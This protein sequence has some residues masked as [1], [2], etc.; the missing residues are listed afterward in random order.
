M[1]ILH[2]DFTKEFVIK[3][4]LYEQMPLLQGASSIAL[5]SLFWSNSGNLSALADFEKAS[6]DDQIGHF[7]L[8]LAF[9]RTYE[10]TSY[11][12][13]LESDL[14]KFVILR[15]LL[16]VV[17]TKCRAIFYY[18]TWSFL[19]YDRRLWPIFSHTSSSHPYPLLKLKHTSS[20]YI[21][22]GLRQIVE[23][24]T[25]FEP[26]TSS[27]L[28][29]SP[30]WMNRMRSA[31]ISFPSR[32]EGGRR[33]VCWPVPVHPE[34]WTRGEN[35][36]G[37]RAD[38]CVWVGWGEAAQNR[39]LQSAFQ[40][41]RRSAQK[42]EILC[43]AQGRPRVSAVCSQQNG[44]HSG[45]PPQAVN[46]TF[47]DCKFFLSWRLPVEWEWL[48]S[49]SLPQP[50]GHFRGESS[51]TTTQRIG[52][53]SGQVNCVPLLLMTSAVQTQAQLPAILGGFE[54]SHSQ[55]AVGRARLHVLSAL[56]E[57]DPQLTSQKSSPQIWSQTVKNEIIS[58]DN[59]IR[60]KI[61]ERDPP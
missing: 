21:A 37:S 57:G 35:A 52:C 9:C 13:N 8:R 56:H 26:T 45:Q 18:M 33:A 31:Q 43:P 44:H 53:A 25:S 20:R 39:H 47:H 19:L 32:I 1:H 7:M 51:A 2:S 5:F 30:L 15:Q 27:K 24:C 49:G 17:M 38:C 50:G 22:K 36:T 40:Q 3:P 59:F 29:Q 46:A 12:I 23:Y 55:G 54:G 11:I 42:K 41:G 60:I 61:N 58:L 34:D 10:H 16:Y 48:F 14:F 28:P 6:R 4:R